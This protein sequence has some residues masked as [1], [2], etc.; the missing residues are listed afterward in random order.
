MSACMSATASIFQVSDYVTIV[1]LWAPTISFHILTS[2]PCVLYGWL[3]CLFVLHETLCNLTMSDIKNAFLE[4]TF[5]RSQKCSR[6]EMEVVKEVVV[7][8][9]Y[10]NRVPC[11]ALL[12]ES[13]YLDML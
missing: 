7:Y 1:T 9:M 4:G 10:E 5:C 2:T 12:I 3:Q 13:A 8:E 11:C 6:A